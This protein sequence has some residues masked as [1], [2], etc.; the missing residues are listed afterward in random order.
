MTQVWFLLEYLAR[1]KLNKFVISVSQA[2]AHQLD[3][4]PESLSASLIEGLIFLNIRPSVFA[5]NLL[6]DAINGVLNHQ[7]PAYSYS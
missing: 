1:E 5:G 2:D 4:L 6:F 7:G 3:G